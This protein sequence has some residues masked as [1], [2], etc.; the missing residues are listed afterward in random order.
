MKLFQMGKPNWQEFFDNKE[1]EITPDV[2]KYAGNPN[3]LH[4]VELTELEDV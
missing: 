3:Q 1:T 4:I 2:V